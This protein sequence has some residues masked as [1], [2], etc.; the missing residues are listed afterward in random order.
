MT[1]L[2]AFY[3]HG[4]INLKIDGETIF[5]SFKEF[6][7]KPSNAVDLMRHKS[8][9]E[10]K[11]FDKKD[12]LRIAENSIKAFL[13]SA[14][15]FFYRDA[16]HFYLNDDLGEFIKNPEFITQFKDTIDYRTRRFYKERLE[17]LEK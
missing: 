8:T 2:L 1:L 4:N 17:K 7:A 11:N 9:K 14:E 15:D 5:Q 13:N 10:Y 16:S 12:Y 3:N 6:Y